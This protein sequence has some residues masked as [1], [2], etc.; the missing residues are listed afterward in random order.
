M[1]GFGQTLNVWGKGMGGDKG[2]PQMMGLSDRENVL[3]TVT[4]EGSGEEK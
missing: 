3:S 1:A 2:N 4:E